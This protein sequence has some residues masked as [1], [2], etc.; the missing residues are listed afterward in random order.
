MAAIEPMVDG[1][2]RSAT[3]NRN[4]GDDDDPKPSAPANVQVHADPWLPTFLPTPLKIGAAPW[5]SCAIL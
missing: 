5:Q 1:R 4:D 2:Y 3:G